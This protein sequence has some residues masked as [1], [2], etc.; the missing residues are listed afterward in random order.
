MG[1]VTLTHSLA[2][3]CSPETHSQ[4]DLSENFQLAYLQVVSYIIHSHSEIHLHLSCHSQHT[5]THKHTH[6]AL[7]IHLSPSVSSHTHLLPGLHST[8]CF[9]IF[10]HT[11]SFTHIHCRH[12]GQRI[13]LL[14]PGET[15]RCVSI[16]VCVCMCVC[17][18]VWRP[19]L[20]VFISPGQLRCVARSLFSTSG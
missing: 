8:N 17:Q 16:C 14:P 19:P 7:Q 18:A 10:T 20:S 3:P 9:G 12:G 11:H 5:F 1:S 6:A 4:T 15:D 13:I 2:L